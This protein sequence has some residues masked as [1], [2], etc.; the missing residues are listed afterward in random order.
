MPPSS[1][2]V[3]HGGLMAVGVGA[4]HES[5]L[6][7]LIEIKSL[8]IKT[9]K[10]IL[11]LVVM[12]SSSHLMAGRCHRR[13]PWQRSGI[14][15]WWLTV[16]CPLLSLKS[17]RRGDPDLPLWLTREWRWPL[18][19][20]R[21]ASL[22]RIDGCQVGKTIRSYDCHASRRTKNSLALPSLAAPSHCVVRE[23]VVSD[24]EMATGVPS[25]PVTHYW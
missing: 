2:E 16:V 12:P 15:G 23:K 11:G 9:K 10:K 5:R 25:W 13:R 14:H 21:Q 20:P 17:N 3:G 19:R 7:Y 18:M 4:N 6:F 1:F 8:I 22:W 24:R